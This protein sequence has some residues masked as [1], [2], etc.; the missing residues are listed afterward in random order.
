MPKR[1]KVTQ[2]DKKGRNQ[3]FHDN[4]NGKDMTRQQFVNEIRNDNYPNYHVRIINDIPTPVSN[5][6]NSKNNNLD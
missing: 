5:P 1:I 6:D 3:Q 2:E 4:F